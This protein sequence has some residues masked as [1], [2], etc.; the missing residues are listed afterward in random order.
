MAGLHLTEDE[1]SERIKAWWKENGTSVIAGTV[2]GI[3]VIGGV[4]YWRSYQADQAEAAAALY[5][6][7]L[8]ADSEAAAEAGRRLIAEY[9]ATPYAGKA[10]LLLARMAYENGDSAQAAEHLRWALNE[11]PD[12]ADRA[13]ARLR[14]ARVALARGNPDEADSLL[15]G[16]QPGGYESAY[17]ELLGDI[18][19]A[20]NDP[21]TARDEY[22]AAIA[23]LPRSSGFGTMLNRKL[24]AAAGASK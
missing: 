23:A 13:V 17:R 4:N 15:A 10:A 16:M 12:P 18:A 5:D 8:E 1:Q 22:Q 14:L 9:S 11:A 2:L 3:A 24:D 20:R 7:A 19:M 6:R 21:A